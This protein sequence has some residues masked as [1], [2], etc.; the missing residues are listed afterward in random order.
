MNIVGA[1]FPDRRGTPPQEGLP[2]AAG[3]IMSCAGEL[4]HQLESHAQ[5]IRSIT[6]RS[7]GAD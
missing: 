3:S 6:R 5:R 7:R 4:D 1:V 2:P